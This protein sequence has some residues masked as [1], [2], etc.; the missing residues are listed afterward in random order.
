MLRYHE[1]VFLDD[2]TIEEVERELGVPLLFVEQDG[3]Q[4]CDAMLGL[5]DARRVSS[6]A[7]DA[8]EYYTYNPGH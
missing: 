4:L 5:C 8:D 3:A 6:P 7:P 2:V 1:N